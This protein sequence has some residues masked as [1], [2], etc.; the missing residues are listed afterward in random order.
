MIPVYASLFIPFRIALSNDDKRFLERSAKIQFGLPS[1]RLRAQLRPRFAVHEIESLHALR[2]CGPRG[3]TV[4]SALL[5]YFV[6]MV[7]VNDVMQFLWDKMVGR[8]IIAPKI[9]SSKTWE[10]F[11]GAA[12][13]T[14]LIGMLIPIIFYNQI[15]PFQWFGSGLHGTDH[16]SNRFRRQHYHVCNQKRSWR[17]GLR[18]VGDRT[19]GRAGSHRFALLCRTRFLSRHAVFPRTK[20]HRRNRSGCSA[21]GR[22]SN[23]C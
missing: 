19:R 16:F 22:Y 10:G 14:S 23:T 6:V 2:R 12:V 21:G 15:T 18:H 17:E 7:Q 8:K 11:F 3:N 13:C 20:T 9:N 1:M 4:T 5:F